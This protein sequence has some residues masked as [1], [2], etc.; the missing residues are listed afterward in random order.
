VNAR[1]QQP[2]ALT[3]EEVRMESLTGDGLITQE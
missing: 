1:R 2:V 3:N